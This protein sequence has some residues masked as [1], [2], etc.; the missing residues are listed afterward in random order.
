MTQSLAISTLS[1]YECA[2]CRRQKKACFWACSASSQH[3]NLHLSHV[4]TNGGVGGWNLLFHSIYRKWRR[5]GELII[6]LHLSDV[7]TNGG[8]IISLHLS[9]V[10]TNGGTCYFFHLSCL[11]TRRVTHHFIPSIV[12]DEKPGDLS[13]HCI[14]ANLSL[15]SHT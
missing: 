12:C 1:S 9:D 3:G 15:H 5:R 6:S 7:T 8:D 10:T 2:A 11:T 13:F 14:G 4:T